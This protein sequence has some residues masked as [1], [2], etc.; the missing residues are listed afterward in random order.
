MTYAFIVALA[1]G[2]A[3]S[4]CAVV[5]Q[6]GANIVKL[7]KKMI[8]S[9]LAVG[10]VM[11]AATC[12]GYGI[13]TWILSRALKDHSLFW[14]H[15]LAGFLL[16]VVGIRMLVKAFR[17]K[18]ILEHRMEKIDIREDTVLALPLCADAFCVGIVCGLLMMH[19]GAVIVAVFLA[20]LLFVV[21]GYVGGQNWGVALIGK[22]YGIGGSILCVLG[23]ILQLS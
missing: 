20:S 2:M 1:I 6:R 3:L 19:I 16:A 7:D 22:T 11:L 9:G 23:I 12:A 5:M 15:A 14:I 17:K 10:A 21:L 18:T 13:G 4:I 8:L